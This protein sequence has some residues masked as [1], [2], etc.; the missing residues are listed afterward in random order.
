MR[1]YRYNN[2]FLS[3]ISRGE[4]IICVISLIIWTTIGIMISNSITYHT[5]DSNQKY[6]KALK[7]DQDHDAFEYAMRTS[8]GDAL[9]YGD[10]KTEVPITLP[11]MTEGYTAIK[12]VIERYEEHEKVIEKKDKNGKKVKKVVKEKEW[13]NYD[14]KYYF[15][16]KI[17]F[18]G[19]EFD[20]SK[21][22]FTNY[23]RI[24]LTSENTAIYNK[25]KLNKLY[26]NNHISDH[27]GD[28]RYSYYGVPLEFNATIFANLK[29]DS[30]YNPYGD[31][32]KIEVFNGTI[33]EYMK[34]LEATKYVPNII[35]FIFWYI[36]YLGAAY[37]FVMQRNKWADC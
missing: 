16:D 34:N 27:I 24:N 5:I 23:E 22:D 28:K 6:Y 17:L 4:A 37:Y 3:E 31:G 32:K 25:I 20:N 35:F 19:E 11:E 1:R 29:E 26:D 18:L 8:S 7:F 14:S 33:D 36:I 21:F 12:V 10:F 15:A 9:V 2:S 13:K 30:I